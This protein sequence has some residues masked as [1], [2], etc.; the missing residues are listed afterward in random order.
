[1][2]NLLFKSMQGKKY[3]FFNLYF[4][5]LI[6]AQQQVNGD[7]SNSVSSGTLGGVVAVCIVVTAVITCIA[8]FVIR[9]F[10][11][12]KVGKFMYIILIN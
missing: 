8:L 5:H 4:L 1:M 2:F 9:K 10:R 7:A 3:I 11:P 6:D 12:N